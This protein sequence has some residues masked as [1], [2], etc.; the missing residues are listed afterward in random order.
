MAPELP[1]ELKEEVREFLKRKKEEEKKAAESKETPPEPQRSD[2]PDE[3]R[4]AL[5]ELQEEA[6]AEA[7]ES[8][9]EEPEPPEAEAEEP[10]ARI[11]VVEKGDSLWKIAEK[12]YGDGT[13]W[14]EI[15][16]ANKD[17]IKDP[18]VIRRGQKLRI[19]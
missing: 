5:E 3:I 8:E 10:E 14:K 15:Y 2:L 1:D 6:E 18:D 11:H 4:D 19:P 17:R 16:R 13:R 12:H 9:V 7:P